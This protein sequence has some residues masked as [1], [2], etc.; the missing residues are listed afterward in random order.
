VSDAS[1][2]VPIAAASRALGISAQ[3]V[4]RRIRSGELQA[5]QVKRP[6]GYAYLV[7]LPDGVDVPAGNAPTGDDVSRQVPANGHVPLQVPD[8]SRRR[9]EDGPLAVALLSDLRTAHERIA[10]LEQERFELAGRLGYFQ[11]QL[12]AKDEQIK[13]L[14]APQEPE[15]EP[16][17]PRWPEEAA[18][19]E[20]PPR[21]WWRFW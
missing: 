13:A 11:A 4:R 15:L 19:A 7:V 5:L 18:P 1:R 21:P 10:R 2:Q 6:Q 14:T 3:A 16:P 17:S 20:S 8:V 12:H 9:E